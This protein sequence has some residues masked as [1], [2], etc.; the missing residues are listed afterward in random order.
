MKDGW[1]VFALIQVALF[2]S[3]IGRAARFED[4]EGAHVSP[5]VNVARLGRAC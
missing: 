5:L 3:A 4:G 2:D 1:F